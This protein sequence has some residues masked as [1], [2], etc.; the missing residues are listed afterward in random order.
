MSFFAPAAAQAIAFKNPGDTF[1]GTISGPYT[2][3]QAYEFGT[4][5]LAYWRDGKPKMEALV[6]MTADRLNGPDDDGERTLYVPKGRMHKAIA[7]ALEAAGAKE[8][9]PGGHLTITFTSWGAGQNPANPP[10]EFTAAYRAPGGMFTA[11]AAPV[12]S[13]EPAWA[14][15]AQAQAPAPAWAQPAAAPAA[16]VQT[17][18][19][20]ATGEVLDV[21]KIRTLLGLNM[22]DSVISDATG[23][24]PE[25]VAMIRS[26]P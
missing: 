13:A 22:P 3:R 5:E 19:N 17:A 4:K 9:L 20:P 6:P 14:A 1:S 24:T 16:P 26:M 12:A 2:E 10:K 21:A 11:P 18:A 7:A 8:L 23:A 15:Q 25:Q